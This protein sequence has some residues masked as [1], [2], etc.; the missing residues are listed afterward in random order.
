M[1]SFC[2]LHC[3]NLCKYA[4]Q[5]CNQMATFN[6]FADMPSICVLCLPHSRARSLIGDDDS[7]EVAAVPEKYQRHSGPAWL[8]SQG[9][10]GLHNEVNFYFVVI[11]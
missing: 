11:A 9:L 3:T 6:C 7:Y 2:A 4:I 1:V 5:C 8:T 10:S